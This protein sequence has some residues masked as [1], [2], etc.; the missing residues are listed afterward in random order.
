MGTWITQLA[1][2]DAPFVLTALR[3]LDAALESIGLTEAMLAD[4]T[5]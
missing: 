5:Y 4:T 1:L 3:L 2:M